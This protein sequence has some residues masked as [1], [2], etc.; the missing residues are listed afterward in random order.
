MALPVQV[1]VR[2]HDTTCTGASERVNILQTDTASS[3]EDK[4]LCT[5]HK[6]RVLLAADSYQHAARSAGAVGSAI[7]L[8]S[9]I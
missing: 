3:L 7:Q 9:A 4:R 5:I 6:S 1:R 8:L 2:E